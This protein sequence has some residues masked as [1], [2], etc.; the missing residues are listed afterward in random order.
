MPTCGSVGF[1]VVV[2]LQTSW[3]GPGATLNDAGFDVSAAEYGGLGSGVGG[4]SGWGES[5]DWINKASGFVYRALVQL[6]L[7]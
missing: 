5:S 7:N 1:V 3:A 2:V 6:R 4:G